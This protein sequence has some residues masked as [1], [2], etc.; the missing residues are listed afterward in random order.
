MRQPHL[1]RSEHE[2]VGLRAL[3]L[4]L[5]SWIVGGLLIAGLAWAF[6]QLEAPQYALLFLVLVPGCMACSN[7][8]I[9]RR[10]QDA[11]K[12]KSGNWFVGMCS[13]Q[14]LGCFSNVVFAFSAILIP[15][16][17]NLSGIQLQLLR[18][19]T[20]DAFQEA[21]DG[22]GTLLASFFWSVLLMFIF[23]LVHHTVVRTFNRVSV[24]VYVSNALLLAGLPTLVFSCSF[25]VQAFSHDAFHANRSFAAASFA[26]CHLWI[27]SAMLA[28]FL[29]MS[30][31]RFCWRSDFQHLWRSKVWCYEAIIM[32]SISILLSLLALAAAPLLASLSLILLLADVVFLY[33]WVFFSSFLLEIQDIS[34][35][36][37]QPVE[38]VPAVVVYEEQIQATFSQSSPL[39]DVS[40]PHS[41]KEV[42][43]GS[44]VIVSDPDEASLSTPLGTLQIN[45]LAAPSTSSSS[46]SPRP[47]RNFRYQEPEDWEKNIL[48]L[49]RGEWGPEMTDAAFHR[50]RKNRPKIP[51]TMIV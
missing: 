6:W 33:C 49:E 11:V 22:T 40:H 48:A 10:Q 39:M 2:K 38:A 16:N 36:I 14:R 51:S 18:D 1:T 4:R 27:T 8:W 24:A 7:M 5:G 21:F 25:V 32:F 12:S 37:E 35:A 17:M 15:A 47:L 46:H 41:S 20:L 19:G 44:F 13:L 42:N 50:W 31:R 3:Y 43:Y 23:W 28:M 45:H 29:S 26:F 34:V 9:G 30:R